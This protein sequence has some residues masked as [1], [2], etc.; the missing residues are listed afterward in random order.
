VVACASFRCCREITPL[1]NLTTT[2]KE[3]KVVVD[4]LLVSMGSTTISNTGARILTVCQVGNNPVRKV[5]V[6]K[7]D[8]VIRRCL[9]SK[10]PKRDPPTG[11]IFTSL[12]LSIA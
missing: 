9:S 12:P 8:I 5:V 6:E 3:V 10:L 11:L 2:D 1:A 4:V 7:P